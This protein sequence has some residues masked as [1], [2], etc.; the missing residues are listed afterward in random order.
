MKIACPHCQHRL[1]LQ[2]PKPGRYQPKCPKCGERF[3]LTVPADPQQPPR[4][5]L[6]AAVA[7][8]APTPATGG[9][10]TSE[11]ATDRAVSTGKESRPAAESTVA[12]P[13]RPTAPVQPST[14]APASTPLADQTLAQG[15]AGAAEATLAHAAPLVAEQTLAQESLA[16]AA[17]QVSSSEQTLAATVA[18][19]GPAA[20]SAVSPAAA[21]RHDATLAHGPAAATAVDPQGPSGVAARP[22]PERIGGYRIVKELGHGAMGDVY[23]A[24]QISLDRDV[25]LKTIRAQWAKNPAFIAR[26]TREAYAAAQLTHHNI[27]QIYDLGVDGEFHYFSMEFVR[28]EALDQLLKR[29]GPLPPR[30][31]AGYIL[32]AARGLYFAHQ[33]GMVHRD[34]KPANLMLNDQGLV[35]VAD[36]GLVKVPMAGQERVPAVEGTGADSSPGEAAGQRSAMLQSSLSATLTHFAVG[37][38]AYMPPEQADDA[39]SVDHRADI[40][41]LGC[42][43][44]ALLVGRSPFE[45][46]IIEILEKHRSQPIVL[47]PAVKAKTPAELI[48][49]TER[50][51]AKRPE[52]RVADLQTVIETLE[53]YLN[54]PTTDARPLRPE[55]SDEL[56]QAFREFN[57]APGK[58]LRRAAC[59]AAV[60]GVGAIA[61]VTLPFSLRLSSGTL[62][63][64]LTGI[65][66]Y[67]FIAG[68]RD[69]TYL[70]SKIRQWFGCLKW[71]DWASLV[72]GTLLGLVI[73]GL[74]LGVFGTLVMAVLA[75]AVAWGFHQ[76]IDRRLA[77]Q[78]AAAVERLER[79]L[80]HRR[81]AGV[82]ESALRQFVAEHAGTEWE[83]GFEQLFGYEALVAAREAW[84]RDAQG[85]SRPRFRP[86][87]DVLIRWLEAR[88][89]AARD[90]QQRRVLERVEAQQLVASGMAPAAARE[91]ASALAQGLVEQA[92][93]ARAMPPANEQQAVDPKVVAEQKRQ[94]VKA[95]L[96]A[97]RSGSTKP[98]AGTSRSPLDIVLAPL[99]LACSGRMRFLAGCLL[100]A[101][102]LAWAWQNGWLSRSGLEQAR[103]AAQAAQSGR[104]LSVL[105]L[106][107]PTQPTPLSL[108]I[109]GSWFTSIAP[110]VAGLLLVVFSVGGSWRAAVGS[111]TGAALILLGPKLGVPGI[112]ALGGAEATSLVLGIGVA[113]GLALLPGG[114]RHHTGSDVS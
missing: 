62:L 83:E 97:A 36:M 35:K 61:V 104:L 37:T 102:C 28:G 26:F 57:S 81:L 30:V 41:S 43:L 82:D 65:V 91:Q 21:T 87:R 73:V 112:A 77:R 90:A 105:E 27:V 20:S 103:G 72:M 10:P 93:A 68:L 56:A 51:T 79:L 2:D 110:G 92:A 32:Q 55:D 76:G 12:E 88:V 50:M 1:S 67:V 48:A 58:T 54:G 106:A 31:A 18:G 34:V 49:L 99:R 111:M 53:R 5:E 85:R 3:L 63:C 109:V 11:A 33:V 95:M 13:A 23:L 6:N 71:G 16:P 98:H 29:E 75:V 69:R 113:V 66:S 19:P 9:R 107:F 38:P 17:A 89:Q 84:G 24:R 45:G 114:R 42:T 46:N 108:P 60:L 39:A 74:G 44:Y 64:L 15:A 52:D 14:T 94:R 47:P 70:F 25:A 40:Y 22:L 8:A 78:R 86:W 100:L 59:A 80:K 101:G 96:A 4:V 7:G